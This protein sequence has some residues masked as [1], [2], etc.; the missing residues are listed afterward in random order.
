[1]HYSK[2]VLMFQALV[3]LQLVMEKQRNL[4]PSFLK[5][6]ANLSSSWTHILGIKVGQF[7]I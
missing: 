3:V 7:Q 4:D 1:V 5:I 6:A 2:N